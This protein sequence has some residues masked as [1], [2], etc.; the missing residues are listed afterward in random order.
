MSEEGICGLPEGCISQIISFT[1]PRDSCRLAAVSTVFKSA[2][3]SD[4]LWERFLPSDAQEWISRADGRIE[5]PSIKDLYFGLCNSVLIDGG[6]KSFAIERSSGKK[7]FLLSAKEL[8]IIWSDSPNYWQWVSTSGSRFSSVA[9]LRSVCW[10]EIRGRIN[11]QMLSEKMNYVVLLVFKI[12]R[13]S[14]GLDFPQQASIKIG[15]VNS[16][17]TVCLHPRNS[18]L[19]NDQLPRERADGWMEIEMGTFFCD[20]ARQG[21]VEFSLTETVGGHWKYGL[22]VEGI[23]LRPAL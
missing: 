22:L 6:R 13:N 12:A 5:Y 20:D 3:E 1:S 10:L 23:E 14:N 7:I 21:E 4:A 11:C 18:P 19:D 16:E 8:R 17:R 15:V 2:A 9:L